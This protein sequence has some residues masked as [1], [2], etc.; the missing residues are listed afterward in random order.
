MGDNRK[1]RRARPLPR[2][3]GA[4]GK[5]ESSNPCNGVVGSVAATL[6]Y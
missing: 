1:S 2:G 5:G 4:T 3:D 6:G